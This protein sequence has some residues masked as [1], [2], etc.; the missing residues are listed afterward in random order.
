MTLLCPPEAQI[1]A[2]AKDRNIN[3]VA[4]P[5][6]RKNLLGL[7]SVFQWLRKHPVD[8]IIT[9][10]ST[11]SWL[12][13]VANRLL[14]SAS[15]IIR[16]RHISAPVPRNRATR[17]LYTRGCCHIVT[18]GQALRQQL[19]DTNHFPAENMTSIP[20]GIDLKRFIPGQNIS[21][22]QQM[23]L[24]AEG[25]VIGIVA[26]LRS[27]KGH[28]HLLEAFAA[29]QRPE[30]RLLIVGD[31]PQYANLEKQRDE[32]KLQPQTWM[33]G[34]QEDVVPWLQACDVF[35]LPSYAN[36]G[37]PQSLMQ[38]M[39]CGVPVIST[40]VGSIGEI[41]QHQKTGLL[42]PPK[43]PTA[44]AQALKMLTEDATLRKTLRTNALDFAHQHFSLER[45]LDQMEQI[46]RHVIKLQTV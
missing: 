20:T 1:F 13:A 14:S 39:A 22:R 9:H 38:A 7:L 6:G 46:M 11:D 10:S 24:P 25:L 32:L 40:P 16:L 23:A 4:L 43:D 36:E 30:H 42:V 8:V 17:W 33:V 5:I 27:W 21:I 37:V 28:H 29:L 15:P 31:G 44:L 18:T 12:T 34:N 45:M 3:V 41:V 35:V 26:T 19:I 2:A